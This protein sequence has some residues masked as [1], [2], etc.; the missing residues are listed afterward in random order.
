MYKNHCYRFSLVLF[1]IK[2]NTGR[3]RKDY[4]L[5]NTYQCVNVNGVLLRAVKKNHFYTRNLT[6]TSHDLVTC[7]KVTV[8]S[9]TVT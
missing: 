8:V 5:T 4:S 1:I 7:K 6:L 2:I 9:H 3:N